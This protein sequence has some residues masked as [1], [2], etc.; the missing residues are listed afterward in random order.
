MPPE[1]E[2][3]FADFLGESDLNSNQRM[4]FSRI[5]SRPLLASERH[6]N[7]FHI[8]N[9]L[10]RPSAPGLSQ[11]QTR[12]CPG[13]AGLPLC[14]IRRK[15]G[16][17]PGFHRICP[18]DKPGEIPGQT[19]GRPKTNLTKKFMFMCPFLSRPLCSQFSSGQTQ[20]S[21]PKSR[22]E[23]KSKRKLSESLWQSWLTF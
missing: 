16:F 14:K 20:V 11:G 21:S 19:R 6:I 7:V 23:W 22:R 10:C 3:D 17:V 12:V 18:K 4:R 5:P 9:S 8:I 13:F 1:I 2:V 15:P